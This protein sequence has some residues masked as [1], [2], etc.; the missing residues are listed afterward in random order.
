MVETERAAA[1]RRVLAA[2]GRDAGTVRLLGA[3]LDHA[4]YDVDGELVVRL[5]ARGDDAAQVI[6]EARLLT[7]VAAVV[8]LPVPVPVIADPAEGCLVYARLPGRPVLR[9]LPGAVTHAGELGTALGAFAAALHAQPASRV[10]GLVDVDDTAP[11]AWLREA[12]EVYAGIRG[13]VPAEHRP[14]VEAFLATAP[15]PPGETRVL[16]HND[17]GAE[18]V[19]VDPATWQVTGIIDWTDA[20]LTDPARDLALPYR[21]LGPAALTAA[22]AAYGRP[23]P[24]ALRDRAVLYARCG[25]LEDLAYGLQTGQAA[26][27]GKT[28]ASLDWL[29]A[30]SGR[31]HRG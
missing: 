24:D 20:A 16:A 31:G 9:L 8:P 5:V 19:L 3:G 27:I 12:D 11:A 2:H 10:A 26:Y 28:L 29:F 14:A 7:A 13:D 21:D 25:A 15:P 17:L 1:V 30:T 22:L 18:H 6:R 23:Q 4:A